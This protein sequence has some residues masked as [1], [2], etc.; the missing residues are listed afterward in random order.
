MIFEAAAIVGLVVSVIFLKD[1]IVKPSDTC[2]IQQEKVITEG[3]KMYYTRPC[4]KE[5]QK[6][7]DV[8]P[9]KKMSD[10]LTS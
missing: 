5:E 2:I 6:L 9:V 4:D 7:K 1:E 8:E 10:N 3:Q